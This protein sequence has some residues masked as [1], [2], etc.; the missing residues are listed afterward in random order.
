AGI[1]RNRKTTHS[2]RRRHRA[3]GAGTVQ[4]LV[5]EW[6]DSGILLREE[7]EGL[8]PETQ[9]EVLEAADGEKAMALLVERVLLTEYQAARLGAGSTFGLILGNYRVLDRL[10]AG[11]MAVVFKAEHLDLRHLVAIK[12]LPVYPEQDPNVL[13]RFFAEMRIVAQ[14]HHPHIVAA[15]DA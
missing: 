12:V 1:A 4:Q 9:R 13:S 15:M 3:Q 14:L 5:E 2:S 8:F 11:G 6:L 7:W 10:G